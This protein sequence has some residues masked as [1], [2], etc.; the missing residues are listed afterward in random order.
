MMHSPRSCLALLQTFMVGTA[1]C[2]QAMLHAPNPLCH[3]M[4]ET[5][6]AAVQVGVYDRDPAATWTRGVVTL[7]GDAANPI[8]PNLGQGG[9]KALEDVAVLAKCLER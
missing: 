6:D 9:N 5:M 7:A 4:I 2:K 1:S 3:V 8:P